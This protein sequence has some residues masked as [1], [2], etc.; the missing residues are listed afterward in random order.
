MGGG[1]FPLVTSQPNKEDAATGQNQHTEISRKGMLKVVGLL[2]NKDNHCFET[3]KKKSCIHLKLRRT[4]ASLKQV[5]Q[6]PFRK[7]LTVVW[8][9]T[10]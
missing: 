2:W 3:L 1:G 4:E 7:N 10:Y 8:D 5:S 6:C 9:N